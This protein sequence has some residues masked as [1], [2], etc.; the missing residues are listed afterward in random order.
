LL[1]KLLHAGPGADIQVAERLIEQQQAGVDDQGPPKVDPLLLAA[2]ELIRH[3]P[4]L[5]LQAQA[6]QHVLHPLLDF[7]LRQLAEAQ[8]E[9]QVVEDREVRKKQ[10][11]L[12]EIHNPPLVSRHLTDVLSLQQN[13]S[14][15]RLLQ[16]GDY[17]QQGRFP[18]LPNAPG[19]LGSPA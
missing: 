7:C 18:P 4:G 13:L 14:S 1:K 3:F 19:W 11:L 17:L 16:S 15:I 8:A 10:S 9:G 2:G 12:V 5:L 6:A